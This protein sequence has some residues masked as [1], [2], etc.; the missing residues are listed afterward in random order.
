[1]G[2]ANG[3]WRTILTGVLALLFSWLI[4]GI[5][6]MPSACL[7][8]IA[9]YF[10]ERFRP[11]MYLFSL[12]NQLYVIALMS[13]WCILVF[14][15]FMVRATPDSLIPTLIWSFGVA[16]GPWGWM[17]SKE[18]SGTA[19][20]TTSTV[21][22]IFGQL[23]YVAITVMLLTLPVNLLDLLVAFVLVMLIGSIIAL[24]L[25]TLMKRKELH[26]YRETTEQALMDRSGTDQPP[27][28]GRAA[29]RRSEP[30]LS[31]INAPEQ[32]GALPATTSESV[33]PRERMGNI[34]R[35]IR[36]FAGRDH[37]TTG[38]RDPTRD[39]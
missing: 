5:G 22:A 15:Y 10:A 8:F 38:R 24:R 6:M 32:Q 1:M 9:V 33:I 19:G 39:S 12:L 20:A 28:G 31:E 18:E 35:A 29:A 14:E 3:E 25:N 21:I 23:G 27:I 34:A 4:L 37:E 11:L 17:A 13:A 30:S 7:P 36:E 2:R 26:Y 16:T